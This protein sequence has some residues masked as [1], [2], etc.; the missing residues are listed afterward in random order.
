MEIK[1]TTAGPL[2]RELGILLLTEKTISDRNVS[3]FLT[4]PWPSL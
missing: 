2:F 4:Q 3:L 1:T